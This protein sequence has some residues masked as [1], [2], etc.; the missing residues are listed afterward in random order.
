LTGSSQYL[1]EMKGIVKKFPGVVALDHVDFTVKPG[2]V[3][4]LLGENGAGKSTL[5]KVLSGAYVADEGEIYIEGQRVSITSPE[6]ALRRGLR[7]IYQ[8]PSLVFDL[9][10]ARNIF[11]GLETFKGG[12]V[13]LR[14]IYRKAQELLQRMQVELD[15]RTTVRNLSITEQKLVEIARAL[16]TEAKVIVLDEP[17]DV[18]EHYARERLFAIIKRL[19]A[20]GVG[21]VYISHRYAE[22]YEI[23]DRVTILRDGKNV[24]TFTVQELSFEAMIEKMVG[25]S[26]KGQ[27]RELPPPREAEAL[28]LERVCLE[29]R[30]R[31]I[32]FAVRRGE[33]VSI[34]GLMGSGKTELAEVIFGVRPKTSGTIYIDGE[35]KDIQSPTQAIQCG[36]AFLP[37]DRRTKGLILDQTVRNNYGLPNLCRLSSRWGWIDF[38]A[39]DSEVDWYVRRLGIKLPHKFVLAGQLSGGNQQKLVLAKWLGTRPKVFLLDEPTRGIDV[40]GRREI[41]NIVS[42]LARQGVAVV[43]FTSDYNE[44]LEISH[45]ILIMRRGELCQE[46]SRGEVTEDAVLKAA[47]GEVR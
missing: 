24:G 42:E 11:L 28:R 20:E 32:S 17:T 37:E 13:D 23:G 26:L 22:V 2:E 30:L 14:R 34:T 41:Y 5:V 43:V 10:V 19:K 1:V 47:I 36:I 38:A 8:E 21:F 45:R 3:H 16:A 39:M 6:V 33:V 27:Q 9:D 18:L 40:L 12:F 44:A 15:P 46:F 35:A 4:V 7:F 29:G 25:K 31:N